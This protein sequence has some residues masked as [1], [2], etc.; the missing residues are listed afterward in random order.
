MEFK[1]TSNK[2]DGRKIIEKFFPS[3]FTKINSCSTTEFVAIDALQALMGIGIETHKSTGRDCVIRCAR[4][5][6]QAMNDGATCVAL[7]FDQQKYVPIAKGAEQSLRTTAAIAKAQDK[8]ICDDESSTPL[9]T[10]YKDGE[11]G[12]LSANKYLPDDFTEGLQDRDGYRR[13]VIRFVVTEW[14]KSADPEMRLQPKSDCSILITGHCCDTQVIREQ[15][16]TEIESLGLKEG[17]DPEEYP[18][19]I[20]QD[21]Y[22]IKTDMRNFIGEGEMQFFYLLQKIKPKNALL[23]STDTDVLFLALL[24]IRK[25]SLDQENVICWRYDARSPVKLF[26]D[27]GKLYLDICKGK[28]DKAYQAQSGYPLTDMTKWTDPIIMLAAA[29]AL[30]GTDYT[31]GYYTLT[32]ESVFTCLMATAD[33][34]GS[35]LIEERPNP[36]AYIKLVIASWIYARDGKQALTP[37]EDTDEAW[38]AMAM[39]AYKLTSHRAMKQRF[40]HPELNAGHFRAR[41]L[42]WCYYLNM[43]MQV[44]ESEL[45]LPQELKNWG[46]GPQAKDEVIT[47]ANV[48]P[49]IEV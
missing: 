6:K 27:I 42:R 17:D 7:C 9:K 18:L 46:Y 14:I 15:L 4:L 43:I 10:S 24:Y 25:Y 19:L 38:Q 16:W 11:F 23:I 5:A 8:T 33:K 1:V 13:N 31:Q 2:S 3:A 41:A 47:H 32:H 28:L 22:K 35:F 26:C 48:F 39:N 34:L 44:G 40:P 30:A 45:K 12:A 36:R 49:L 29:Q 37:Q 21:T 20:E